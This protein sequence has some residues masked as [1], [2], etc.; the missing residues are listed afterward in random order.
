MKTVNTVR[1]PVSPAE[2]GRTLMHEHFLYGFCGFQGDAT[3]GGFQE[4]AA[5]RVCLEEAE[6]AKAYGIHTVVDATTNECGRNVRF[7]ERLSRESGLHIICS[8]GYYY[9][10]E[11]AYAYWKFRQAF[12]N[13]EDEICEMMV[14]ELTEGI[15]GTG[16]RAGVI[17]LGS[18]YQAITPMEEI[19]FRAAARAQK[20]TG[21]AVI[22]HTQRGT[23]GPEQA[24]LLIENGANPNK[25]AIGHMCG[26]LDLAYHKAVLEQGVYVNLDRFGLQ[27]ELFHTPTDAQRVDLIEQLVE[28]G[29]EDRILLGHDTVNVQLG[30]PNYMSPIME[31]AMQDAVID[32]L[33]RKVIPEM[34]RRGFSDALIEKF[35]TDNPRAFFAAE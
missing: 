5:L 19:F 27:G 25:L 10:Q 28:A 17:K 35:F 24:K 23:M 2:L 34:K 3:L 4:E 14:T 13:V 6:K 21:C 30:R 16:I 32:D 31:E 11:S 26:N 12:A 29:Y 20:Q 7:L 8:T 9:E 18:S 33:G 22:T 15:E 1:G